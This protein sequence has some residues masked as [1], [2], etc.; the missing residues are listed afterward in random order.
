MKTIQ[1]MIQEHGGLTAVRANYICI[2]NPPYMRLVVEVVGPMFPN[3]TCELSVAHYGEQN[4]DAMRDPEMTFL[5]TPQDNGQWQWN[6]LT[7][8]N[9]YVSVYQEAAE[10]D[11]FGQVRVRNAKLVRELQE[12]AEQ[13][14]RNI[15]HQGFIEAFRQQHGCTLNGA[16]NTATSALQ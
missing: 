10:Y 3:G 12:F 14:D 9:D 13:W 6:P 5:V 11:N 15:T 1:Q 8:L 4:G 2:E 7:F 16:A